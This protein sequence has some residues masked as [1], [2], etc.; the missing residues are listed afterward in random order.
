MF[1]LHLFTGFP[2][3]S[4]SPATVPSTVAVIAIILIIILLCA[5]MHLRIKLYKISKIAANDSPEYATVE[6]NQQAVQNGIVS[7]TGMQSVEPHSTSIQAEENIAYETGMQSMCIIP[8]IAYSPAM[9]GHN[10]HAH[11]HNTSL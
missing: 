1:A 10:P 4:V 9:Q 5:Y 3:G 2:A 8:N 11:E 7:E 6:T